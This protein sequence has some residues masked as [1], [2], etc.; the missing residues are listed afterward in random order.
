MDGQLT[1]D[2]LAICTA[3]GVAP[4]DFLETRKG[5]SAV[6]S[7]ARLTSDELAI[8]AA[9]GVD[10]TAYTESRD[11]DLAGGG[12]LGLIA[13]REQLSA[14][15]GV[16]ACA[17]E[18]RA[19]AAEVQLLPAGRFRAVDGRPREVD[20]WVIDAPIAERVI[21]RAAARAGDLVIDYEHQTLRTEKNGQPAPA[22]G[23]FPGAALTWRE[24]RGLFA[25]AVRWTG[26]ARAY[27]LAREYKYLSPVFAYNRQTGEV[28]QLLHVALTNTPG[29]DGMADVVETAAAA[30]S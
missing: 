13:A 30:V 16:G 9:V 23:W 24:G 19:S 7:H 22:A 11:A 3:L 26:Q 10:P 2:E 27:I 12:P 17:F 25:G 29:I 8:C 4:G 15:T 28:L 18:L 6:A 20:A 14:D 21:A 5:E 1:S